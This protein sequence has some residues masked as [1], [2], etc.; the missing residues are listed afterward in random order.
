LH[1]LATNAA[2]YGALSRKD[3]GLRVRWA[4]GRSVTDMLCIDWEERGGP[5][6]A[7]PPSHRGFGSVLMLQVVETQLGGKVALDWRLDGL[8]ASL[9]LPADTWQLNGVSVAS[10]ESGV[11]NKPATPASRG[12]GNVL[13][14]EDEALTALTLKTLL[15]DAGY[16]VLGPVGRIDEALDLLRTLRPDAAVLDVNLFGLTVDPVAAT[17]KDMGVPFLFCTGY[18][19]A[20]A[21]GVQFPTVPVLSKPVHANR[22]L[23]AVGVLMADGEKR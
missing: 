16:R 1:E 9:C 6:V 19:A 11:A 20:G 17:L 3:G 18:Q 4:L 13:V 2:K 23:S 12:D 22:L 8:R 10:S 14:V 5:P 21:T 15:E 7:G